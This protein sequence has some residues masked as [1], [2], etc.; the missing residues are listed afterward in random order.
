MEISE[1]EFKRGMFITIL[2]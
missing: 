1:S 2:G